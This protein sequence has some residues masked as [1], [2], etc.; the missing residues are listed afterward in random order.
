MLNEK[1]FRLPQRIIGYGILGTDEIF[2]PYCAGFKVSIFFVGPCTGFS[3]ENKD[4]F[5]FASVHKNIYFQGIHSN[6]YFLTLLLCN[7]LRNSF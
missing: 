3:S 6:A 7:V 2:R 1:F 5:L 4:D